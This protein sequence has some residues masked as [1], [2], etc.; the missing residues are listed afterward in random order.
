MRQFIVTI[1]ATVGI[2]ILA[3]FWFLFFTALGDYILRV[4]IAFYGSYLTIALLIILAIAICLVIA[5]VKLNKHWRK[6]KK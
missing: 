6:R 3:G 1:L 4:S 2:A 5:I